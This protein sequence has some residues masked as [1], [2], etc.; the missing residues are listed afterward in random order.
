MTATVTV[1]RKGSRTTN[2]SK[3]ET[4]AQQ[5]GMGEEEEGKRERDKDAVKG[6]Q[7]WKGQTKVD[8]VGQW[9]GAEGGGD[10]RN[11]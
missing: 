10:G 5:T 6:W 9:G 1:K 3:H 11:C 7:M 2:G 4:A 8:R